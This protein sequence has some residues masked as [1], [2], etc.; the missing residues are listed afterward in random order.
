[1]KKIESILIANRGE[2]ACRIIKT[3]KRMG[4][5][6]VAL[7]STADVN[8]LHAQMADETYVMDGY[9]SLETYLDVSQI[10]KAINITKVDAVHPGYGFL[11]ENAEFAKSVTDEGVIFIGPSHSAIKEMGSKLNS[12]VLAKQCN[13]PTLQS[14][15]VTSFSKGELM[16]SFNSKDLPLLIKA[17]LGGGGKGMRV[18]NDLNELVD[19]VETAKREAKSA[20]SDETVFIEKY[21]ENPRHIEIQILADSHDN[22]YALFERECSI[23]RRHQKIIEEAPCSILSDELRNEMSQAAIAV[24]RAVNY[25]NAGTVEFILDQNNNF[26]FLEMNTRLQVE[27]PVTEA[28]TQLDLVELQIKIAQG[29]KIDYLEINRP[30]GHAIELRLYAED[31]SRDYAP[32]PGTIQTLSFDEELV[33]LDTGYLSGSEVPSI[34]DPM[35]A[36]IIA[37]GTDRRQ[38]ILKLKTALKKSTVSGLTTNKNLLIGILGEEE[39]NL[40]KT[41]TFY[42]QRHNLDSLIYKPDGLLLKD[43]VI[44]ATVVLANY[45]KAGLANQVGVSIGFRNLRSQP[46]KLVLKCQQTLPTEFEIEY[47][48]DRNDNLAFV[49]VN[50]DVLNSTISYLDSSKVGLITE[51]LQK[52]FSYEVFDDASKI[53]IGSA[54]GDALFT[55]VPTFIDPSESVPKG[56]LVAPMP[57]TITKILVE[58]NDLVE[59]GQDLVIIEAMKMENKVVTPLAGVVT[60]VTVKVG[61]QVSNNQLLA[62]IQEDE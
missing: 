8:G 34:Y 24:A 48:F 14:T 3:A 37:H 20:F 51:N 5:Y 7:C 54:L 6:T 58:E 22:V 16:D 55:V 32:S 56:S 59:H 9:T 44:A 31:P 4:I 25:T 38:A 53:W 36:K 13:V 1:M 39:F 28:I 60:S 43:M 52:L 57:G 10:V 30:I 42:L 49:A 15:D 11:S 23:Q 12:K 35:I 2:I 17:S 46:E 41:D 47:V 62:I 26:Y 50:K 61:D 33:R 18:I 27:H 29:E 40:A 19:S 45:Y 21:I